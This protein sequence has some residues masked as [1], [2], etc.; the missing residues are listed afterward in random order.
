MDG[1]RDLY[2]EV[3]LD[4]AK[5]PRNFRTLDGGQSVEGYN[6]LCGDRV[7]VYLRV[8]DGIVSDATFQGEG[9]AISTASTSIMTQVVK[10]KT[11][12]EADEL[13]ERFRALVTGVGGGDGEDLGKLAVFKGVCDYP[14][15][16]KCASLA[17]HTMKAA[18]VASDGVVTTE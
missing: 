6:P 3:I 14:A 15:R 2:Q 1:Y 16:V 5:K 18:L 12:E 8:E 9:C 7:T 4:H 10:G 11:I 13:F 17:W